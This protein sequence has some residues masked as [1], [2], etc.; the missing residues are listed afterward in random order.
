MY[1][2]RCRR[3]CVPDRPGGAAPGAR[4][5]GGR[6]RREPQHRRRRR[7]RPAAGRRPV[8]G[9]ADRR[10]PKAASFPHRRRAGPHPRDRPQDGAP[11]SR[12]PR[13]RRA[14]DRDRYRRPGDAPRRRRRAPPPRPPP[15][16]PR[17]VCARPAPAVPKRADSRRR[18]GS[19]CVRASRPAPERLA[20][21]DGSRSRLGGRR[22]RRRSDRGFMGSVNGQRRGLVVADGEAGRFVAGPAR[23][24]DVLVAIAEDGNGRRRSA[25]RRDAR[26]P[27]TPSSRSSSRSQRA[28]RAA[29][30]ASTTGPRSASWQMLSTCGPRTSHAGRRPRPPSLGRSATLASPLREPT[31][32]AAPRTEAADAP[33]ARRACP[34]R[35]CAGC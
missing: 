29:R 24:D 14:D 10:L 17:P 35:W 3:R 23:L 7:A 8:E 16:P 27:R 32:R 6:R 12:P 1:R 21:R 34:S 33:A 5:E 26:V 4:R 11:P 20:R 18:T 22:G 28:S 15:P 9:R 25:G 13:R 2:A 30:K 19:A 31:A